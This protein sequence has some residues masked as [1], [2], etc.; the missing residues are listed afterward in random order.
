MPPECRHA[1]PQAP[2]GHARCCSRKESRPAASHRVHDREA[3]ARCGG[4]G[5][6]RRGTSAVAS[7]RPDV[8]QGRHGRACAWTS[9]R[10][11]RRRR[12]RTARASAASGAPSF[13]RVA[14]RHR[15]RLGQIAGAS[16][17]TWDDDSTKRSRMRPRS[18]MGILTVA[19]SL[20]LLGPIL[21]ASQFL[22]RGQAPL[23]AVGSQARV[24]PGPVTQP[25]ND[26]PQPYQ[27]TRTWGE[28]P[29]GTKAWAAVTAIEPAPDG[30]IYVVH[31]CFENSCAG[32][33]RAADPEV[34]QERQAA[35]QLRPGHV[36]LP[37]RRHGRSRRQLVDDRRRRRRRQRPSG[38][39]AQPRAARC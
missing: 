30:S 6:A 15:P 27:T 17:G 1:W 23:V 14:V 34:R 29:A 35:R 22:H 4:P 31:R 12:V 11:S 9:A 20:L 24:G 39:Q 32:T 16:A 2:A 33:A 7:R 28:L 38:D 25:R 3:P 21:S 10:A 13:R 37:A 8:Q 36:R 19:F 5:P 18:V 26:L